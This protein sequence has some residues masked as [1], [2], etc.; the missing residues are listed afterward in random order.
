MKFAFALAVSYLHVC[1]MILV[2][3]SLCLELMLALSLVQLVADRS[4]FRVVF[5]VL[6]LF[7]GYFVLNVLSQ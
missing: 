5:I 6:F 1:C 7:G 3:D 4:C 2:T